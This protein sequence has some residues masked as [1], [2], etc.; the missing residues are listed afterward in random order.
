[1]C[2]HA[3]RL[4]CYALQ[5]FGDVEINSITLPIYKCNSLE[6]LQR[7]TP[8][9]SC[10][11]EKQKHSIVRRL[12]ETQLRRCCQPVFL[13]LPTLQPLSIV[14]QCLVPTILVTERNPSRLSLKHLIGGH[15]ALHDVVAREL[16]EML[17]KDICKH[18][19]SIVLHQLGKRHYIQTRST[20]LVL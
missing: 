18:V 20:S 15:D 16:A 6:I 2:I 19:R 1:M 5:V 12:V 13:L 4:R 10:R 14:S 8:A 11:L 9:I 17:R 3:L 7:S